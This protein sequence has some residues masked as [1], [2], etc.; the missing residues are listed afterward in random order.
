MSDGR[1]KEAF[2]ERYLNFECSQQNQSHYY[3]YRDARL[4]TLKNITQLLLS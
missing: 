3:H 4:Y 2:Y 1:A